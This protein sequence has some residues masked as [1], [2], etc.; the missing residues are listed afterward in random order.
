MKTAIDHFFDVA[1]AQFI[2]S[3]LQ[4]RDVNESDRVR[5]ACAAALTTAA[6]YQD[7]EAR[8]RCKTHVEA[9]RALHML[10]AFARNSKSWRWD[11][12][13]L[14]LEHRDTHSTVVVML[15]PST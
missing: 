12:D 3:A 2:A 4:A 7:I 10:I 13:T 15:E 8:V 1:T 11:R 9:E 14:E 6:K 5:S